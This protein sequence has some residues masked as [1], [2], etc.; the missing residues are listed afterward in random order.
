MQVIPLSSYLGFHLK[1][2]ISIFSQILNW[3]KDLNTQLVGRRLSMKS[4]AN[5]LVFFFRLII[6]SSLKLLHVE[7]VSH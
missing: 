6:D 5:N 2:T 4:P 3:T 7:I 1:Q